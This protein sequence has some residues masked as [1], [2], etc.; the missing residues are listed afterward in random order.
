M[1]KFFLAKFDK[2][3][4]DE[5]SVE[6]FAVLTESE[7]NLIESVRDCSVEVSFDF[8][9]NEGWED[10][11]ISEFV[12]A[13]DIQELSEDQYV[14][15]VGIFGKGFGVFPDFKGWIDYYLNGDETDGLE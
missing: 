8:G 3:W 9:T 10:E 15:L 14:C 6:G 13:L 2:D 4:A 11:P 5:F 12:A 1:S 7:M